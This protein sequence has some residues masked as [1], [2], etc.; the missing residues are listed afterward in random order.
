MPTPTGLTRRE[1]YIDARDLQSDSDPEHPLTE[2]EYLALLTNRGVE[3]L[4]EN[5]LVQSFTTN[6][7]TVKPTYVYGEDF[8]IG[9]IITVIDERIGVMIDAV[10]EGVQRGVD[11]N[12]EKLFLTFGYSMPNLHD[13]LKRKAEK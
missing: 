2:S 13:I 11:E 9:D 10:V 8:Q 12:G 4:A 6:I 5:Q 1:I 7:R 3:K